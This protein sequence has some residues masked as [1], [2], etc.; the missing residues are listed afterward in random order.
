MIKK[1]VIKKKLDREEKKKKKK[2]AVPPARLPG[3]AVTDSS[4]AVNGICG[5][6]DATC[7][8]KMTDTLLSPLACD[9]PQPVPGCSSA[10]AC[11][12]AQGN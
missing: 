9:L 8:G 3:S 12:G 6:Q 10:A 5:L 7:L 2:L 11:R 4:E 1:I